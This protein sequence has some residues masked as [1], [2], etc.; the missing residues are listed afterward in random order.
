[1]DDT[2]QTAEQLVDNELAADPNRLAYLTRPLTGDVRLSGTPRVTM[3]ASLAGRSP[4]LTALLV[5][6][7]P[8][9]EVSVRR[10]G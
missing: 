5:D 2:A 1:M 9:V 8:D 3:R 10:K 4:Y 6:Y 7:G